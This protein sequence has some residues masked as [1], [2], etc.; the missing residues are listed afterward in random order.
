MAF[1]LTQIRT[2]VRSESPQGLVH[3]RYPTWVYL[4]VYFIRQTSL[5]YLQRA[6]GP[7]GF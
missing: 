2:L 5:K 3:D 4:R 7:F 6:K 1:I